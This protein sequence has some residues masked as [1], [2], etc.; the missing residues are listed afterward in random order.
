[1]PIVNVN[2][3]V[4]VFASESKRFVKDKEVKAILSAKYDRNTPNLSFDGKTIDRKIVNGKTYYD[5]KL[6]L[7]PAIIITLA[8]GCLKYLRRCEDTEASNG[9]P[10]QE[11]TNSEEPELSED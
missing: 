3:D 1:M 5:V 11:Q 6:D 10:Q 7:A 4:N 2:L 8:A 9:V